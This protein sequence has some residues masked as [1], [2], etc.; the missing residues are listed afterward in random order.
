M[1]LFSLL[2]IFGF[3]IP[4]AL[5][6]NSSQTFHLVVYDDLLEYQESG[7]HFELVLI[8]GQRVYVSDI[9]E[10]SMEKLI[11]N[12]LNDRRMGHSRSFESLIKKDIENNYPKLLREIF[13][14][15]IYTLNEVKSTSAFNQIPYSPTTLIIVVPLTL[16]L[17]KFISFM[18]VG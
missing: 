14:K 8:N 18:L 12:I 3:I 1:K 10:L 15:D 7:E 13:L 6:E 2:L 4:A 16:I 9:I 17:V 5:N 11:V